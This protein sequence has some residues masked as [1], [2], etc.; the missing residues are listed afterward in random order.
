MWTFFIASNSLWEKNLH[1]EATCSTS[2]SEERSVVA[3]ILEGSCTV[4]LSLSWASQLF[5][6]V[7]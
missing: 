6:E 3:W 5:E 4:A 7:E 1:L 2:S